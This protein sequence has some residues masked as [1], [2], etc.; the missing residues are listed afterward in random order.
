MN[1]ATSWFS[2]ARYGMF[3]HFGLYS[4]LGRGEWVMNREE[5]STTDYAR[6]ADQFNPTAFDAEALCDLAVTAGMRYVVFTT[7]HHEGFRL[8]RSDLSDFSSITA[9]GRD[10]TAE[11]VTAARARGLRVGLYHSLNNWMDAP[12]SVAA[13]E[14]PQAYKR[15]IAATHERCVELATRYDMDTFWFDGWWPFDAAGWQA[16]ALTARIRA[17]R[18]QVLFNPRSGLAGDFSTPEG[19]MGPP[20]PWRPWEGCIS[21]NDSWGH[22]TGDHNWKSPAQVIDLL[23]SAAAGRGNLLLNVSPRAD[24]SLAP[25]A[26]ALLRTVGAWLKR[27]GEAIYPASQ[28]WSMDLQK[29]GTHLGDWNGHG[30]CTITGNALNLIVKRWPGTEL[31]LGGFECTVRSARILGGPTLTVTQHGTRVVISGLP[32]EPIDPLCPVIR[33]ECDRVPIIYQSG[34]LRVPRVPHPHYDPCPSELLG[35]P[36]G[37]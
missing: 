37:H 12:D 32:P 31:I 7:M 25:Q 1:P 24:G 28:V 35:G 17:I 4:L 9:C 33:L 8:Y 18:P 19:H 22:S 15:F 26:I 36:G 13:L 29:R 3:I 27:N 23:T 20:H 30:P 5:W 11:V 10:L 16:E 6:L 21:V 14:D 34:G 2:E